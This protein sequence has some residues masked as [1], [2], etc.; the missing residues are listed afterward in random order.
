MRFYRSVSFGISVPKKQQRRRKQTRHGGVRLA[1][2]CGFLTAEL[3]MGRR[4]PPV[5][6]SQKPWE[7]TGSNV[8]Y[9]YAA[10]IILKAEDPKLEHDVRSGRIP[11][12]A[13]ARK[14][15]RVAKLIAAARQ[16]TADELAIV[17][18]TLTPG[19]IWDTMVMPA[20]R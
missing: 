19:M 18:R 3:M 4:G 5:P 14:I 12:A 1:V 8:A 11:L 9:A 2:A 17:G 6:A 13:A 15:R 10:K 16:A 7:W 20:L